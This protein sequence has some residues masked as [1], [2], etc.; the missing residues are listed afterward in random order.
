MEEEARRLQTE[1]DKFPAKSMKVY[2]DY[3]DGILSERDYSLIRERYEA[4]NAAHAAKLEEIKAEL[5][6]YRPEFVD[7]NLSV[8]EF[9]RFMDGR[10]LTRKMLA[11]LVER[12][13]VTDGRKVE[14]IFRY[15]D[16][17]AAL[18]AFIMENGGFENE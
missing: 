6:R 17:Y 3:S 4:E 1:L 7:D 18:G 15:R 16:E 9:E 11:A 5:A 8:T 14:I 12:V 2:L 13:E 10:E